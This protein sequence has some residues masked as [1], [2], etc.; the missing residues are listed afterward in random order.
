MNRR[1]LL[2]LSGGALVAAVIVAVPFVV[3][4]GGLRGEI[5]QR[6]SQATGR[7]FK[8]EGDLAFTLFP[9]LGLTAHSV[10]LANMPGGRARNLAEIDVCASASN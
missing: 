8:I 3:P 4:T 10:T 5:E 7:A 6:V 1:F 2:G 9:T